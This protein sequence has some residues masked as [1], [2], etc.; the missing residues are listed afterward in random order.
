MEIIADFHIHSKYSRATSKDMEIDRLSKV[1]KIKGID[2][3]STGDFTHPQWLLEL[4]N[5]L[6]PKS[7]GIYGHD[8]TNFI[9]TAEVN[10]IYNKA[11]KSRRIHCLIFAP[12][13]KIVKEINS[14]L[15]EFGNLFADGRPILKLDAKEMVKIILSISK[16]CLIIP[17]HVWTPWFGLLG[18]QTGFDSV[19]E[20]FEEETQNIYAIETGLSSDPAMNWR[21]SELD[22]FSLVS[23]SDAHSPLNIGREANVFNANLDYKEIIDVIKTKDKKKFLFTVEFFPQEGKY[24]YDGHRNCQ[25]CLSPKES[26]KI[27]NKCPKCQKDLTVGVMHRVEVLS[28]R[29]DGYTDESFIPFKN[30]IPLREIISEVKQVGVNTKTVDDEYKKIIGRFGSEFNVLLKAKDDELH[31][32]LSSKVAEGIVRV[33]HKKVEISPGYDGEY[34]KIEIF[35]KEDREEKQ[36]TLF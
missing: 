21:L 17:A 27:N 24:H 28:D 6:E 13:F 35:T 14:A 16:D 2:L 1:A 11:G 15:G 29:N 32:S 5:K 19:Q 23:N 33:R 12:S 7:Y 3:L 26:I 30:L 9:L 31:N 36:L 4:E 10:N 8:S 34:G 20:C 25:K 22:R 18:S